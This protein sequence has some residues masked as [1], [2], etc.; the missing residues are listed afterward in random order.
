MS[1]HDHDY[2]STKGPGEAARDPLSGMGQVFGDAGPASF[3]DA[4]TDAV[5]APSLPVPGDW[6]CQQDQMDSPPPRLLA[7]LYLLLRDHVQPGDVE[8]V[9]L[10]IAREDGATVFCNVHLEG[11]A[12]ALCTYLLEVPPL[13]H[14]GQPT[15]DDKCDHPNCPACGVP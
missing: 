10:N 1:G 4:V 8:Q 15:D 12:R 9:M 2:L 14:I 11:Y 5:A 13:L 7:A 3:A 6:P